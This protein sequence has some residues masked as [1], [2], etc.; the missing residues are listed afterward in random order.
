MFTDP[1]DAV[2]RFIPTF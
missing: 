2:M 1:L